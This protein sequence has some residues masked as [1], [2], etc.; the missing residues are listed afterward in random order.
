MD[1]MLT[2]V[3]ARVLGS[4]IEK[5]ITTPDYYPLTLNG[6]TSACN[7]KSNRDPIMNL[8]EKAVVRALDSLRQKHLVWQKSTAEGRVPKYAHGIQ[9]IF[10]FSP[11]E[12]G[13]LCI[14]LLRGA[15]T[16]GEIRGRTARLYEFHDLAELETTLQK[17][18]DRE[19]GPMVMKLPRLVGHREC[20][21]T[22]LFCGEV[23]IDE[24]SLILPPETATLEVQAENERILEL[25][26]KV[27]SLQKGLDE[28]K[29]QFAEFIRQFE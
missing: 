11:Q 18:M 28:L 19:D 8:D 24:K 27:D 7:Q 29:Q 26:Q 10:K 6:L 9:D 22:H 21:Y 15:Q 2:P 12:L 25:E 14:L 3:E 23:E 1:I 4:L 17:L 13:V 20:R 5:Q 16:A